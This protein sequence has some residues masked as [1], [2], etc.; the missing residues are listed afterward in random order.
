MGIQGLLPQLKSVTTRAHVSKFRGQRAAV[1]AYVLLHRG[2]YACAREIV[3]RTHYDPA[4]ARVCLEVVDSGPGVPEG[5]TR[6]GK[7]YAEIPC[8]S[9]RLR[10]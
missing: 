7:A 5:P 2:A 3:V 4:L 8:S 10:A 6:F 9:V 1:D